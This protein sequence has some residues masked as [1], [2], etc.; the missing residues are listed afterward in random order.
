MIAGGLLTARNSAFA[1]MSRER[2]EA[3]VVQGDA[4]FFAQRDRIA[5]LAA[6]RRL[7]AIY[8][9]RE[10]VEAGGLISYGANLPDVFRRLSFYVDKILKGAKPSG[11]PFEQ[12]TKFDLMINLNTAK[13]LGLTMPPSLLRRADELVQ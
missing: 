9:F 8:S 13:A 11:L 6:K 10:H 2:A 1:A 3:L 7:P 12:A 4:M 5:E